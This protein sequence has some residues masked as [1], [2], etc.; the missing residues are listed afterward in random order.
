[1]EAPDYFKK[2][3]ADDTKRFN[4]IDESLKDIL[5][6]LDGEEFNQKIEDAMVKA[7]EKAGKKSYSVLLIT[8]GIV[9]AL[10]IIGGG[11]KYVLAWVGFGIIK[12]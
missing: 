12:Q 2:H 1:M 10:A 4:K 11:L 9:G 7:I 5:K 8:A 3:E 6:K